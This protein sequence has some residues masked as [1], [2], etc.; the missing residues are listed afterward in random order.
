MA[1]FFKVGRGDDGFKNQF[2]TF[3]LSYGGDKRGSF[4][5]FR[6]FNWDR[7]N[8]FHEHVCINVYFYYRSNKYAFF[9][10]KNLVTM[11]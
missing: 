9:D 3:N 1:L 10:E 5:K 8:S 11:I 2:F 6:I 7:K 4:Q